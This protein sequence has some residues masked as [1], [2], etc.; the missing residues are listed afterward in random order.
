[1]SVMRLVHLTH[2]G[3]PNLIE[4]HTDLDCIGQVIHVY[5]PRVRV[6]VMGR[7]TRAGRV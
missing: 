4:A 5:L 2:I 3:V 6:R 1:M 7:V